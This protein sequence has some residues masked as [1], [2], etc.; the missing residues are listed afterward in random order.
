MA[1]TG[2]KLNGVE[3]IACG[4]AT[5][6]SLNAVCILSTSF[7]CLSVSVFRY[8]S[9]SDDNQNSSCQRL[10]MVEER[11]G[12]LV[13][14]EPSVIEASLA[15]YGDLVYQDRRSILSK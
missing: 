9:A 11:V 4:L 1:L 8:E 12:K 5:H 13:T 14:D 10:A 15:Q 6:Y 2:D 7:F 3:M